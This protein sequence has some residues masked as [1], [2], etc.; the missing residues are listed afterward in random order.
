[1]IGKINRRGTEDLPLLLRWQQGVA[2]RC[3]RVMPWLV[4]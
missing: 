3:S 2:P 1:M 4:M